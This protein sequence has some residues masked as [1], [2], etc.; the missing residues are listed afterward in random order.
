MSTA[1]AWAQAPAA[2][3]SAASGKVGVISI[4]LAIGSTAEGKLAQAE[5]Q[6][7]FAP[8][9]NEIENLNK[10]INDLQ[11]RLQAG[12]NKLS[13]E[14]EARLRQQGQRLA[15][16]LDRMNTEYQEDVNAAL[17]DITDRI[18][19]KMVDVLDRY[20]RE[21]GYSVVLDSSAQ[22]T[23]II[24][25][26]TQIDV[27]Q[28]IVRLFDQAYPVKAGAATQPKPAAPKPAAA[29]PPAAKP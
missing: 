28:D 9:Q 20:A 12:A 17:G 15:Q 2:A 1:A 6:S 13:Q 24:Y 26:S 27:T 14:E 3:G 23:P 8:R 29:Q 11:Q 25:A 21:N 19:R 10:Q 22:S 18:G 7:Q 5:L 4:R 16:R